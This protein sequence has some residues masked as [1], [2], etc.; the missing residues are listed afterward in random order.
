LD[1]GG[2]VVGG[3]GFTFEEGSS[4]TNFRKTGDFNIKSSLVGS[5]TVRFIV[6][7]RGGKPWLPPILLPFIANISL[8]DLFKDLLSSAGGGGG[9]IC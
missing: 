1:I 8:S 7:G 9:G 2:V 4:M 3:L 6:R 5:E